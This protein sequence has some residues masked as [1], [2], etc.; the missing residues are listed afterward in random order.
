[1]TRQ[2][3]GG[4][5]KSY[6]TMVGDGGRNDAVRGFFAFLF[7]IYMISEPSSST[8]PSSGTNSDMGFLLCPVAALRIALFDATERAVGR[9]TIVLCGAGCG[10]LD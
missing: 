10:V 3:V 8:I 1:M 5:E 6:V 7:T 2:K 9:P 4:P